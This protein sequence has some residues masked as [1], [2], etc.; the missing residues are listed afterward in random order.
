VPLVDTMI[1]MKGVKLGSR[2]KVVVG[3]L[4]HLRAVF[5]FFA[6]VA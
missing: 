2:L 3:R 5:V 6:I 1:L 4:D